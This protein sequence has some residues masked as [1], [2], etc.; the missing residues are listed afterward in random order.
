MPVINP[1]IVTGSGYPP[2]EGADFG[3]CADWPVR[4]T[5]DVDTLNPAITGLA[6][7]MATA[8]LWALTGRQF[9]LCSIT[10]R[11][12]ARDCGDGRMYD[13]AGPPWTARS[14]PS[15][16]LGGGLWVNLA[17]GGCGSGCSC[18]RVPEFVLPAP[19][20][21]VDEIRID[22]AALPAS[23]Y[24]LDNNRIVV[25]TDGGAW[26]RCND[27]SLDDGPGTWSVTATYGQAVPDGAAL[28]MGELACE[29]GRAAD[30]GDCR[31]PPGVQQL[32]R[33]GVT[34]SY[35]DVGA[36]F[37]KG[38]TGL[39]LVDLFISTWNPGHLR[40]RSRVYRV[41]APTVRRPGT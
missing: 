35:P 16:A 31:L 37:E 20:S 30:G 29:I 25:R 26:P 24:R 3:P 10:L 13:D 21:S 5:C 19:V 14:W 6:V 15:A 40:Q 9:G 2:G 41:D 33:Q 32:A 8:T 1:I 34:I 4:W 27:L 39:Y 7:S 36:L 18:S 12:C 38:R 28:A 11:P 22:G 23:A 17:C